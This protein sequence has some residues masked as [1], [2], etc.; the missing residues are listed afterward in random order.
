MMRPLRA[1]VLD[2]RTVLRNSSFYGY[3]RPVAAARQR[4]A[5]RTLVR[6]AATKNLSDNVYQSIATQLAARRLKRRDLPPALR[7]ATVVG[8]GALGWERHGLWPSFERSCNFTHFSD[9]LGIDVP[10]YCHSRNEQQHRSARLLEAI[11]QVGARTPVNLCFFYAD[12]SNIAPDLFAALHD[13]GIW[14]V[15][16]GL[17]DRHTFTKF[18]RGDLTVGVETVAPHV[19]LYWTSWRAGILLLH[20]IGSRPWLGGAAAD[21]L[22][23]R[24]MPTAKSIDVLFLGQAYGAR[25]EIIRE[26]RALGIEVECRGYG[27]EGGNLDFEECIRLFSSAKIVLGI[28]AVGAMSD[29]TILKGRDF[30]APMCGACYVTQYSEELTDFFTLGTDLVCYST[31]FQAAEVISTL[32]ANPDRRTELSENALKRS[33]HSNTWDKRI[34]EMYEILSAPSTDALVRRSGRSGQ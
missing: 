4:R 7:D 15:L 11:D 5:L 26:L 34:S 16:M 12:S 20:Q 17:D 1:Y 3:Y 21:P 23:H 14:T 33:L 24:P 27:W 19:D 31:P 30:E 32:L 9:G 2:V 18:Q 22:F 25:R 29:V 28:S 6:R 8:V 13:R 10:F